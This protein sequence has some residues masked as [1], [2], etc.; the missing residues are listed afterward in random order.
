MSSS[1][2]PSNEPS[3][4]K[5]NAWDIIKN[6]FLNSPS[7]GIRRINRSK[8]IQSRLFWSIT[9]LIF[10]VLMCVFIHSAIDKFITH[11]TKINLSVRQYQES[12]HYPAIT[13]CKNELF[14]SSISIDLNFSRF[15]FFR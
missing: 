8:T 3:K 11:P 4:I 6:W 14:F 15:F 5:S 1:P 10:T 13:F 2:S 9:F 7:H 12:I